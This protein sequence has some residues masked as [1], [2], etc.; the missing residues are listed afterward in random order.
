M[1][2]LVVDDDASFRGML[3]SMLE[4]QHHAVVVAQDGSEAMKRFREQPPDLVITDLIMPDKEGLETIREIRR[5]NADIRI[6]AMSGG[7]R[8]SPATY[9][10]IALDMGADAVLAKPFSSQQLLDAIEAALASTRNT[11]P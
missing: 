11:M 9:L 1:V 10:S 2:I 7:G 6:I 4:R 3:Q 5:G 8:V